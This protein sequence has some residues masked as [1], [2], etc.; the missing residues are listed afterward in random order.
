M[1]ISTQIS[2]ISTDN[3][4]IVE[5]ISDQRNSLTTLLETL[6]PSKDDEMIRDIY[7]E[8][9]EIKAIFDAIKQLMTPPEKPRKRIGFHVKDE[10]E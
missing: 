5:I 7:A 2:I 1:Y 8:L 9:S 3:K 10:E 6:E 4:Q